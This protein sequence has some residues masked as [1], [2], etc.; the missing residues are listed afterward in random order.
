MEQSSTR[1]CLGRRGRRRQRV[2][3]GETN[4]RDALLPGTVHMPI[5]MPVRPAAPPSTSNGVESVEK[6]K[7]RLI[8]TCRV[9]NLT[10]THLFD[11]TI[12]EWI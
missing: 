2:F 6:A 4:P 11:G 9:A 5:A 10:L 7:T 1:L 3:A 12:G 8:A